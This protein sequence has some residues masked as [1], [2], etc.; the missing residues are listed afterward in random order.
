VTHPAT[1][2]RIEDALFGRFPQHRTMR[3]DLEAAWERDTKASA[4]KADYRSAEQRPASYRFRVSDEK[5][6]VLPESP[7]PTDQEIARDILNDLTDK[8]NRL[9]DRLSQTNSAER[10]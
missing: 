10:S 5:I 9:R 8:A 7:E 4:T 3:D 6:D 2:G 1:I